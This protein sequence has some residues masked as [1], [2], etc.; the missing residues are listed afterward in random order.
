MVSKTE[1]VSD[2]KRLKAKA[3]QKP[4]TL[5]PGTNHA[6]KRIIIALITNKKMPNENTVIGRVNKISSG[7]TKM[8]IKDNTIDKK[9]SEGTPST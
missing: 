4:S 2:S 9:I 1:A 7:F 5:K 8:F 6:A 3:H